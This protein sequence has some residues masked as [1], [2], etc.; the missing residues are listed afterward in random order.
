M[1]FMV[2]SHQVRKVT[3][4]FPQDIELARLVTPFGVLVIERLS[5]RKDARAPSDQTKLTN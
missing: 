5:G 1:D 3:M 2:V 4:F